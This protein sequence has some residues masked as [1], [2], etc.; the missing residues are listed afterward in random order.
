MTGY[1]INEKWGQIHFWSFLIAINIVFKPMHF[2][3]L[4]GKAH[5]V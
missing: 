3:G 5:V 4:N 1:N 2:L